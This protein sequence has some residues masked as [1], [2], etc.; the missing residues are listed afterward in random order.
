MRETQRLRAALE[1]LV[2]AAD[3]AIISAGSEDRIV[4]EAERAE[5]NAIMERYRTAKRDALNLTAAPGIF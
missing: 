5:H 3:E 2:K 1:A 4:G